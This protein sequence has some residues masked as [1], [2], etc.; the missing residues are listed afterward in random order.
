MKIIK[1]SELKV[2][3]LPKVNARW[4]LIG[5]F[6]L[7]FDYLSE[8]GSKV[9]YGGDTALTLNLSQTETDP[10]KIREFLFLTQRIHNHGPTEPNLAEIQE[11]WRVV[12]RLL[13][14][15]IQI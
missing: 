12:E 14:N 13:S 3:D 4:H 15:S 6:A 2:S 8:I 1:T 10:V 5:A 7:T 9:S 11:I